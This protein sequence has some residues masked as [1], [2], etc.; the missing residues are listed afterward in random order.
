MQQKDHHTIT[1]TARP[2]ADRIGMFI[3]ATDSMEALTRIQEA[4]QAGVQQ[5]WAQGA[6]NA[7]LLTLFAVVATHT[8]RIK[9]GTAIVPTYPRHPLV[10]AQQALAVSDFAPGRLRLGIGPGNPMLIKDWYGLSQTAPLPYLKEY[11]SILRGVLG[12][13][14][15]SYHGLFF[16]VEHT[17]RNA[18]GPT[19][20][21]RA[22]V[23]LLTSAVG[24]RAFQLA[25]EIADGAISWMCPLPYLLS[26]ALPALRTGAEASGRP[27]PPLIAHVR[28]ALCTDESKVQAKARQGVQM[29]ARFGPYAHMFS[30]AGFP[31]VVDGDQEEIDTLARTLVVRGNETTMRH[32]LEELLTSGLDELMLHLVPIVDEAS[33]REQLLHLISSFKK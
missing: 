31:K 3:E 17:S 7:D 27:T 4:E 28:V 26:T 2:I 20:L 8:Q 22:S 24:P 1:A 15:I 18:Y 12:Q 25:G 14:E 21:R 23:P 5:V 6:G 33:E 30:K 19:T 10:M 11:L 9:L 29:A 32:R 16:N 13:G